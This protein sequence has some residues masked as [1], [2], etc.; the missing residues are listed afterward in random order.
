MQLYECMALTR[1]SAHL[2]IMAGIILLDIKVTGQTHAG[3]IRW[4]LTINQQ[5]KYICAD[6][7]RGKHLQ[8]NMHELVVRKLPLLGSPLTQ[9]KNTCQG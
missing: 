6:M 1:G 2:H 4:P 7:H 3:F 5:E 8:R 9:G